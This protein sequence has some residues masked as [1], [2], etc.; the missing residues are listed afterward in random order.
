MSHGLGTDFD[1]RVL[2]ICG[3][4]ISRRDSGDILK[5]FFVTTMPGGKFDIGCVFV[6]NHPENLHAHPESSWPIFCPSALQVWR[7]GEPTGPPT[8]NVLG[9]TGRVTRLRVVVVSV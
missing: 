1:V 4:L 5:R 2:I 8:T 6:I 3:I 9:I 7:L